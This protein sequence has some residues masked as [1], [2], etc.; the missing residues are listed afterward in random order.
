M[1]ARSLEINPVCYPNFSLYVKGSPRE[2]E[3]SPVSLHPHRHYRR[4]QS[5]SRVVI[6]HFRCSFS[7]FEI[8]ATPL[9]SRKGW[10]ATS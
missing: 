8:R 2:A 1:C 5:T 4:W 6:K 7:S 10:L 9:P 3:R